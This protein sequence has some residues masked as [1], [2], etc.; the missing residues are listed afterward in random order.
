MR[1]AELADVYDELLTTTKKLEKTSIIAEI[2]EKTPPELL[3]KVVLLLNGRVYPSWSEE[4][5]GVANQLMIRAI[6]KSAGRAEKDVEED[7]KKSGDLG[8]TAENMLKK[9]KQMVLKK[10]ALT[11]DEV[12]DGIQRMSKEE[13]PGSQERKLGLISHLLVSASPKE[14]RYIV[15][16]V[17]EELRVG[18]AE[19]LIR[20]AIAKAFKVDAKLV[21]QAWF[22]K[23]D[24]GE[25]AKIARKAHDKGLREV[26][27][28]ISKP[29][30]VLLGEKAPSLK[31]A[32]ESFEHVA[33]EKKYDGLRLQIQKKGNHV[34]L[35]TRRQENVTKQ[36]PEVVEYSRKAIHADSCIVEGECL[37]I[38]P[39]TKRPMPFQRLSQRIKRKYGIEEMVREIPVQVNL[40]D[41]IYLNGKPVVD[42][43][44]SRRRELLEKT[45]VPIKGKFQ[46]AEQ[47]ITKDLK[48][49]E[50]F[51]KESLADGQEGVMVKNLDSKY[52]FGRRVA[53]GWLKVKPVLENLDLVII[54]G[55]WGTGK[56][57]GWIGSLILGVRDPKTGNFLECGMLGTGIKEKEGEGASF[58]QM[59]KLLKPLIESEK[60]SSI[61][62]K[63]KVVIEVS[64]QEI[65]RSPTY[66]S[67]FALRF[68]RFV[69]LRDDKSPEEAD[70]LNRMKHIYEMQKSAKK[71]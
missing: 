11:V 9:R 69:R 37:A 70:D 47:L 29:I 66:E 53:G 27:I 71:R 36:F 56:R 23:Q 7:F 30:A 33:L 48:E 28:E 14:A 65:Q 15:R 49:A 6:A 25:V 17:L 19:G 63:P 10:H 50:R 4:V 2:L 22:L 42:E 31:E 32:I 43:K 61:R 13:G 51:Y 18:V 1:Y 55:T 62:I 45:V 40:F 34:W 52:I 3:S 68:P 60:G 41:I 67:G 44:F 58:G 5:V 57:T 64:Y 8:A 59:T 46:F 21:E 54:G 20:D 24:Y 26:E 16:T 12:F 35:F 38:D 39:K